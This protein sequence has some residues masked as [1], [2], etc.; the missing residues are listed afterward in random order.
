MFTA[1]MT[2][3]E[4][5]TAVNKFLKHYNPEKYAFLPM[6][7]VLQ[8]MSDE[9]FDV[10]IVTGSN[11]YFVGNM[12]KYIQNN[13]DY[14]PGKKYDFSKILAPT[15]ESEMHIAGNGLKLMKN[16]RF[17]VV[18]DNRYTQNPENKLYIVD[19]EGKEIVVKNLEKWENSKALF[20]AGNSDGD[21]NDSQFIINRDKNAFGI[22]VNPS[23]T[24]QLYKFS[25]AHKDQIVTLN[26]NEL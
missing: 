19:H 26:S 4:L 21:L 17:S 18:Y 9:G 1:G 15:K 8:K 2:P 23:P 11:Q 6:L 7:D 25:E 14:T 13:I 12:L 20:V 10:W 22:E 24:S 16:N 3:Q 5:E